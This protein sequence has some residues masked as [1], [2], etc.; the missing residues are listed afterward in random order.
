MPLVVKMSS[1]V[2]LYEPKARWGHYAAAVGGT[3]YVCG[4]RVFNLANSSVRDELLL[5]VNV[6]DPLLDSWE[7]QITKGMPFLGL[8][9][10]ACASAL[11]SVYTYGGNDGSNLQGS[12]NVLD[13]STKRWS[14]LS[15]ESSVGRSPMIK[16]GCGLTHVRCLGDNLSLFGGYCR[17]RDNSI[18]GGSSFIAN[19]NFEDGRGWSNEFHLYSLRKGTHMLMQYSRIFLPN[20]F[21]EPLFCKDI[22][23]NNFQPM[24]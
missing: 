16:V 4:G 13:I 15:G 24:R 7:E 21:A 3:V 10:G 8:Y 20:I 2:K 1:T 17:N 5:S 23:W 6:F 11:N 22:R 18:Q 19:H 9:R 12:L 14:L